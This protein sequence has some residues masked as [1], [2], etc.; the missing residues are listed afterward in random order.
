MADHNDL[1]IMTDN[2]LVNNLE[3]VTNE[4]KGHWNF[5]SNNTEDISGQ[6]HHG[7]VYNDPC[8]LEMDGK[9]KGALSFDGI[10][11]YIAIPDFNYTNE[12][13]EF[14]IS[15][16]LKISDIAGDG[17]GYI[18]SHGTENQYNNLDVY[19][20]QA[21]TTNPGAITTRV[22]LNYGD[23][24]QIDSPLAVADGA[25]HLYTFTL[26]FFQGPKI[27]VDDQMVQKNSALRGYSFN[28]ATDIYI[29][30]KSNL[31]T[32]RYYGSSSFD[33]GLLDDLRIYNYTLSS[34]D[35]QL[36]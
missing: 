19:I 25:W 7:I 29:A 32:D 9:F 13:G 15:F 34:E 31:T 18:F 3:P 12:L 2:W 1:K 5:D 36:L 21:G 14:S 26:S 27:Y 24:W 6:G 28:P 17:L 20:R 35:V 8:W 23:K 10:N 16:W 33:D 30:T 4:A 11:D 22:Q